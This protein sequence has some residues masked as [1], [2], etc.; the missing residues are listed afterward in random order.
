MTDATQTPARPDDPIV[1]IDLG[2]TNSLVAWCDQTGPHIIPDDR[3]RNLLPSVVRFDPRS[4]EVLAVGHEARAHAV[5]FPQ[6]TVFSVKRLMGRGIGDV[7]PPHVEPIHG[8]LNLV[9][10][11]L[12][13]S[14]FEDRLSDAWPRCHNR[15]ESAFRTMTAFYRGVKK[16]AEAHHPAAHA[17]RRPRHPEG[18]HYCCAPYSF[19]SG[20]SVCLLARHRVAPF[21]RPVDFN[22]LLTTLRTAP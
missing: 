9:V 14:T 17:A 20:C 15:D 7:Q 4:G 13:L 18:G 22:R 19:H 6:E 8:H 3:G 12:A 2:T 11:D 5:E 10:G 21:S 16:A 1:G